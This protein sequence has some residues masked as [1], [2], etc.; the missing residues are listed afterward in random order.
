MR[1]TFRH[2]G[3]AAAFI[4][5]ASACRLVAAP[6]A[7]EP[8][9]DVSAEADVPLVNVAGSIGTAPVSVSFG[10]ILGK[11]SSTVTFS[12][13]STTTEEPRQLTLTHTFVSADRSR[14]ATLMMK[15]RAVCAQPASGPIVCRVD[16]L[17]EIIAATGVFAHAAVSLHDTSAIDFSAFHLTLSIRGRLCGDASK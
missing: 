15:A 14:P 3:L 4:S 6:T 10:S 13:A 16:Q 12:S 7:S 9:I 8:C 1:T 17:L 5:L 2:V 11:L